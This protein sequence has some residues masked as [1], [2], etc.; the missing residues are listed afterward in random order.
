[1]NKNSLMNMPVSAVRM[2]IQYFI[3]F[4]FLGRLTF[5]PNLFILR[6]I[7]QNINIPTLKKIFERININIFHRMNLKNFY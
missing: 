1:M 4:F 3:L 2:Q 7:I 6:V 5:S